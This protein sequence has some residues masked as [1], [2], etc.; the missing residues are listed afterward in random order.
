MLKIISFCSQQ[1]ISNLILVSSRFNDLV[2]KKMN[3]L[4]D[5]YFTEGDHPLHLHIRENNEIGRSLF[6]VFF[7]NTASA[8]RVVNEKPLSEASEVDRQSQT[9]NFTDRSDL[10]THVLEHC[11]VDELFGS[12][13]YNE[14]DA[15]RLKQ[16]FRI[17]ARNI[18]MDYMHE[19]NEY[20]LADDPEE[21]KKKDREFWKIENVL[22]DGPM[23]NNL[24]YKMFSKTFAQQT[25]MFNPFCFDPDLISNTVPRQKNVWCFLSRERMGIRYMYT[26][27]TMSAVKCKTSYFMYLT[28]VKTVPYLQIIRNILLLKYLCKSI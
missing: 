12:E 18:L 20:D 7:C 25:M 23:P 6:K 26:A 22:N 17:G 2:N 15:N 3:L 5:P 9:L 16:V 4:I 24:A 27:F 10:I 1:D 19:I 11:D 21:F 13:N 28:F 8:A 14:A